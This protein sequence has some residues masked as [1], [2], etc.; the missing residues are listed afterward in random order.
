MERA[1]AARE[2]SLRAPHVGEPRLWPPVRWWD[3]PACCP[4]QCGLS[5]AG[6]WKRGG[7]TAT[8]V[9]WKEGTI[10]EVG[11]QKEADMPRTKRTSWM[12]AM[13]ST[14]PSP[15]PRSR[16]GRENAAHSPQAWG[17]CRP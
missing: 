13:G 6:G 17:G 14:A 10:V 7:G 11:P 2:P 9:F 15:R 12:D 16:P 3:A 5:G 8:L 1:L 4:E